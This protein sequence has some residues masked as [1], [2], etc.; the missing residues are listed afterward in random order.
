MVEPFLGVNAKGDTYGPAV[1]LSCYVEEVSRLIGTNN[2]EESAGGTTGALASSTV[3][4]AALSDQATIPITSRVTL[5]S[6]RKT[7]VQQVNIF[8]SGS[9]RTGLDH[10]E[11]HLV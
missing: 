8:D 9:M 3:L 2:T 7:R 1:A 10:I 6:G 11:A 4:Y 5:P